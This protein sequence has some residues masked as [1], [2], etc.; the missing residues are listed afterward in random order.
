MQERY[1]IQ[2]S[3]KDNHFVCTDTSYKIVVVFEKNKFNETQKATMLEGFNPS[4]YM[5]LA[6]IM[7]EMVDY[8]QENHK[9]LL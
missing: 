5:K 2:A 9:E 4:N 6:R 7:R 8:L 3:E 1:I